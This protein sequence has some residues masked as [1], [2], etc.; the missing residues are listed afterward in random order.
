MDWDERILPS[1]VNEVLKAVVA[2]YNAEQLLTM[3]EKV[4]RQI[5]DTLH[6]R[7]AEFHVH[8]EDISITHLTFG[9]EFAN[10]IEA[11]QVAY[12]DA[13]RQKFVVAKSEQEKK[14]AVIRAEGEA[15]AARLINKAVAAGPGLIELRRMEAVREVAATLARSK[16]IV[17]LPNGNN[18]LI[19]LKD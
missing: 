9:Q 2:Q 10:A 14:A 1:I 13:E 4:S 15:E 7:A 12:Q 5:R 6:L 16:N 11:K 3:R 19:N 17:F 18:A 8:L